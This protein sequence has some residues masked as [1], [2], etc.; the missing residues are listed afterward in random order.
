MKRTPKSPNQ[1][2]LFMQKWFRFLF[3]RTHLAMEI[4]KLGRKENKRNQ[5][6]G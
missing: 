5:P 6:I 1:N 3:S 2:K 4:I